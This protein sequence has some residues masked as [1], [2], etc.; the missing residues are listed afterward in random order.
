MFSEGICVQEKRLQKLRKGTA[1]LA[2]GAEEK[3]S[4]DVN[5][6]PVGINYTYPASFRK[7][8]MINFHDSFSIKEL[9]ELY[10]E[11]PAKALLVFNEKCNAGLQ[12][13]VIIV[14][15]P[16]DDRMAEKLFVM[17]R[18]NIIHPFFKWKFDTDDRRKA[19]KALSEKINHISN[20]S[21]DLTE[22]LREKVKVYSSLLETN[23]LKDANIARRLDWGWLR[24]IAVIAG[25]P[26]YVAGI[27][28][29]LLPFIVPRTL[30]DKLIRDPRFYSSFYITTGTLLYLFYFP[31]VLILS[32]VFAGMT[33]LLL[34]LLIPVTG[35]LALF[36]QEIAKERFNTFR[37]W[38]KTVTDKPLVNELA[39][40]R[41]EI[42]A[43]V[44]GISAPLK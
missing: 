22:K 7:E 27:L 14:E 25:F 28:S 43:L 23:N 30:S 24:Y 35:Y 31:L 8:V 5:I 36:Y 32:G 16:A 34:A 42:Q 12:E 33:G 37:Y 17:T 39:K 9:T 41:E 3:Y 6:V 21:P 4:L 1:R 11:H 29:N 18:N 26:V 40:Q 2:F 15:N 44:A 19:E 20:S 10:R 38:W 13:E